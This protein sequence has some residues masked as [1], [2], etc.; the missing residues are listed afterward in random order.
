MR[1]EIGQEQQ[2]SRGGEK[3]TRRLRWS[4]EIGEQRGKLDP[5]VASC[6]D[7]DDFFSYTEEAED[8]KTPVYKACVFFYYLWQKMTFHLQ[9]L[10]SLGQ[11]L[12]SLSC[13]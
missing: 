13:E 5:G 11:W 12:D 9:T 1:E 10:L 7:T 2:E 8:F 6:L 4:R 3:E